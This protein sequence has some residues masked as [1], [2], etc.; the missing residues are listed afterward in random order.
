MDP[1][2]PKP[3]FEEFDAHVFCDAEHG[4]D[5]ITGRSIT[6]LFTMSKR[7]KC[8]HASTFEAEFTALKAAVEEVVMLRSHL[9]SMG[10]K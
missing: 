9:R 6:G 5:Q 1:R 4:H 7:Q 10:I 8:V 2:F 3:M